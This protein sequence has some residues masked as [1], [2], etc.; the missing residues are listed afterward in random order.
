MP[1]FTA[2]EIAKLIRVL[3]T[4]GENTMPGSWLQDASVSAAK[5]AGSI[6]GTKITS[7]SA[8]QITGV[9]PG[10][11]VSELDPLFQVSVAAGITAGMVSSWNAAVGWGDHAAAGYLTSAPYLRTVVLDAVGGE[12]SIT[13]S[14]A[15]ASGSKVMI[16]KNRA[17]LR[18]GAS[19]DFTVSG[20]SISLNSAAAAF[21]EF[22][23]FYA[24]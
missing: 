24:G 3:Q 19:Y 21:D 9:L 7:V 13:L 5:L 10:S 15:A 17:L 14:P 23:V 8:S 4:G 11:Q 6:P 16:F 2:A 12:N 20:S 22:L 1:E 18:E